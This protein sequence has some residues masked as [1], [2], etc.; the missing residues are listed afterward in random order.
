M[1][2]WGQNVAEL[3]K[4]A[5]WSA[6]LQVPRGETAVQAQHSCSVAGVFEELVGRLPLGFEELWAL[7]AV[8]GVEKEPS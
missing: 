3:K 2:A 4:A 8:N 1:G 7:N 6:F 5:V